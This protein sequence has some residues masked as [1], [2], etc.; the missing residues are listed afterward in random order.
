MRPAMT[1]GRWA[2]LDV[3]RRKNPTAKEVK[4]TMKAVIIEGDFSMGIFLFVEFIASTGKR[5]DV[6]DVLDIVF[7]YVDFLWCRKF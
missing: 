7:G 4:S 2:W 5:L 1:S 6:L 3:I